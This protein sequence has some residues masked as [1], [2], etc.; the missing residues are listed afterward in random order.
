[1]AKL[2]AAPRF[3]NFANVHF[4]INGVVLSDYGEDGGVEVEFPTTDIIESMVG[5]DGLV[6][7]NYINDSRM[8][9]T[10]TVQALSAAAQYL[11]TLYR[12]FRLEME[13]TGVPGPLVVAMYD[14]ASGETYGSEYGYFISAPAFSKSKEQG[15]REFV[16]ELPN[17][18]DTSLHTVSAQN[19]A[20]P[21]RIG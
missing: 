5:A 17:G 15:T 19:L 2:V 18:R 10:I 16:I 13:S 6:H 11:Y 12:T 8:R 4:S 21:I 9:L 3:Y 20:P 1:M 7:A 14:P